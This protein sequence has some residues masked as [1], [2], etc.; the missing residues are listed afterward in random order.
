MLRV[1]TIKEKDTLSAISILDADEILVRRWIE[2]LFESAD[3]YYDVEIKDIT[4]KLQLYLSNNL[5]L[6]DI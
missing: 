6:S 2:D 5:D 3:F 4:K 1:R